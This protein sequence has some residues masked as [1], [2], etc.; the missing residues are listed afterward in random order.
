MGDKSIAIRSLSSTRRSILVAEVRRL[1]ADCDEERGRPFTDNEIAERIADL[2]PGMTAKQVGQIRSEIDQEDLV[3]IRSQNSDQV[4]LGYIRALQECISQFDFIY[5]KAIL[6][7][8]RGA[9][10]NAAVS[11]IKS[12][13][14]AFERMVNMGVEL[15]I[16]KKD[17]NKR[18]R[19]VG[20]TPI[21]EMRGDQ[22]RRQV[23]LELQS[24]RQ[25]VD[26]YGDADIL[27]TEFE[28]IGKE[29][30][31]AIAAG[32]ILPARSVSAMAKR[33][34]GKFK[35]RYRPGATP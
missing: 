15:G 11:A 31:A 32:D 3:A 23:L 4:Y 7:G 16:I 18:L 22:L 25:L 9:N 14:D 35:E 5:E 30:A 21:E 13:M 1:M 10:L 20:K 33:K 34:I 24:V 2:F 26:R 29:E 12:K 17:E 27:D 8:N 19:L 28:E 6:E